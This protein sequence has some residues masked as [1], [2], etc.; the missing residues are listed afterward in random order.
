MFDSFKNLDLTNEEAVNDNMAF[1]NQA[2]A[3]F[4]VFDDVMENADGKVDNAIYELNRAGKIHAKIENFQ[5]EM[6]TVS[7]ILNLVDLSFLSRFSFTKS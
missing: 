5:V 7:S 4:T 6:F 3:I 2:V 1:E